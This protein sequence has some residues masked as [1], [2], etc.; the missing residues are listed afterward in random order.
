MSR[1]PVAG[2]C[3]AFLCR[4][5]RRPRS[6]SGPL[7]LLPS[8]AIGAVFRGVN[9]GDRVPA[10]SSPRRESGAA[11]RSTPTWRQARSDSAIAWPRLPHNYGAL[12]RCP[13]G[14]QR[15]ALRLYPPGPVGRRMYG[16]GRRSRPH[17]QTDRP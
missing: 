6:M 2:A 17:S 8:L 16:S 10:S 3:A 14:S 4:I 9:K 13:P 12:S 15:C 5:G 11:W 7:P 1:Q